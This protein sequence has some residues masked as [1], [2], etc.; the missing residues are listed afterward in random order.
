MAQVMFTN[1][2]EV[3]LMTSLTGSVHDVY[4][5][6]TDEIDSV[7]GGFDLNLGPIQIG[8]GQ[9]ING[10]DVDV[11]VGAP[12]FPVLEISIG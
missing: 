9:N 4:E 6:T 2:Y 7:A 5:L 8:V 12:D 10:W 11:R 1:S 3:N